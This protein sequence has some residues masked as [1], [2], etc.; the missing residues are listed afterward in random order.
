MSKELQSLIIKINKSHWKTEEEKNEINHCID[1]IKEREEKATKYDS[2]INAKPSEALKTLEVLDNTISPLLEPILV[3][4][5]D[6]LSDKITANYFALKQALIKAQ[7]QEK[8][9]AKYKKVLEIINEYQVDIWLLK[10]CDYE[11]YIRIR[12]EA[13]I[14][15][16]QITNDNGEIIEDEIPQEEFD[17][18]KRYLCQNE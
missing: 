8:E 1:V 13:M 12:K 2:I 15:I 9:N 18:L 6:D 4:Y 7:E 3:E 5:E 17:T 16:R 10:Q 11:N 14:S